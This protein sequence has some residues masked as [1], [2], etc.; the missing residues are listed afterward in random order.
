MTGRQESGRSSEP[1]T[2][3]RAIVIA[4]EAH[5]GETGKDGGPYILHCLRVM[6]AVEGHEARVVAVLHDLL[7]HAPQWNLGRLRAEGCPEKVL[8]AIDAMT[9]RDGED[10]FDFA[11]RAA[12]NPL[13]RPVKIADLTDNLTTTLKHASP[14]ARDEK[15]ARYAEAL[16]IVSSV[17]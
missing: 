2:L 12:A 16:R 6:M 10:Y 14:P 17:S 13:A 1:M 9:R 8:E 4:A 5:A 7:E 11:R 15:A 3:E